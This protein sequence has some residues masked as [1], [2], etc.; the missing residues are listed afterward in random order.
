M[1][2]F[3]LKSG[4]HH[5]DISPAQW[6]Y[7]GF[8]WNRGGKKKFF[9]FTVLPFGLATASYIFT[10]LLRPLVVHWRGRGF[11]IVIYL[12]HGIG[13]AQGGSEAIAVST[14]VRVTLQWFCSTAQEMQLEPTH[15]CK[16]VRV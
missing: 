3:D 16:V 15:Y 12:D 5:V 14:Y 13:A 8:A 6:K 7:L 11:K 1:F 10:K 9:V 2:T 4:Y